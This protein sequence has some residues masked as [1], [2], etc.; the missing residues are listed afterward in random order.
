MS[1]WCRTN[2]VA[3]ASS[4]KKARCSRLTADVIEKLA[5]MLNAYLA[6]TAYATTPVDA[7][8]AA[9]KSCHTSTASTPPTVTSGM[10]CNSCHGDPHPR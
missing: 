1:S 2:G 9:C 6:S 10:T 4:D 8:T 7:A 5:E 3:S